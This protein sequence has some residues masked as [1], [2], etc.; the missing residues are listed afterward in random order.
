[1]RWF[2]R[3]SAPPPTPRGSPPP[4]NAYDDDSPPPTERSEIAQLRAE[5]EM[6][7]QEMRNAR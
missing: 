2:S 7:K 6:L 3:G 4:P 1:L 5:L